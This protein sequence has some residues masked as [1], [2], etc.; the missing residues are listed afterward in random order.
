MDPA[1]VRFAALVAA[2]TGA[3]LQVAAVYADDDVV[4]RLTGGQLGEDLTA[5]PRQALDRVVGELHREGVDA[6]AITLGATSP[7]R[8]L[9]LAAEQLGAGLVVV[10]SAARAQP[11]VVTPGSTGERLLTGSPCAVAV[12]PLDWVA[13]PELTVIGAGFVDTAEGREAV[14]GAH[15]LADRAGTVL[16]VLVAVHPRPWMLPDGDGDPR[17][18]AAAYEA[19]GADVRERAAEAAHAATSGLLGAPVDIDVM[20]VDPAELLIAASREMDVLVCGS[21]GYGP[22]P[23]T[24]VGGVGRRVVA[25]AE[26]PVVVAPHGPEVTLEALVAD[27]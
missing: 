8:A 11:G 21:R 10:G 20:V 6:V 19:V 4:D 1:P 24:L 5:T 2:F 26:C 3:P 17:A 27:D 7:S 18:M 12:V 15:A 9:S 16:R 23:A 14:R 25:A 13:R 22:R